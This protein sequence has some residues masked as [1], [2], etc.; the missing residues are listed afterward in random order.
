MKTRAIVT[1]G[2]TALV[3]CGALAGVTSH[4]GMAFASARDE[5]KAER[6]A[7]AE[8][9][10]ARAALA[11]GKGEQAVI[12]A[13]AA[14]GLRPQMTSFRVLLANSYLRAGRFDSARQAFADAMTLDPSNG[15]LPLN[16]ALA[17]IATGDWGGARQTLD[18]H[19]DIIPVSDRGLAI[20]L[21]GD[22]ASAVELLDAAV[23]TP[24]ADAKTRQNFA[25]SLALAGRWQD[26]KTMAAIDLAPSEVDSRIMQWAEFARP[27]SAYDQV[28]AL[29]GVTPVRD[30]GQP[31][32]LALNASSGA[33]LAAVLA[34]VDAFM[35][36]QAENAAQV[37][38]QMATPAPEAAPV[39]MA[40]TAV[41]TAPVEVA[42]ATGP[43]FASVS[44]GPREEVVQRLPSNPTAKP[45]VRVAVAKVAAPAT[46]APEMA[47][48]AG[49][50]SYFVQ[51]GAFENAAVAK[52]AWN[53]AVRR[54]AN[55][56]GQTPSGMNISSRA[57]SFYR[58]SVGGFARNEAVALCQSYK[59]KGGTCFVR[60]HAGDQVAL[61]ARP[62][63]RQ[64]ASR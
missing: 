16:L 28:S 26:A 47:R 14:V 56:V 22:P 49:K 19:K 63:G 45:S 44:F 32:A 51:L 3:A 15:K 64:M 21:A 38:Q 13:E 29:L 27:K 9:D 8:A 61:W 4:G 33:A 55:F 40:D 53:R 30:P 2:L 35:P 1:L 10:K 39:P 18:A 31:V 20:A 34:P 25:L 6:K 43:A 57:G 60:A 62:A 12:H 5:S 54:N 48:A 36:G 58:L 52:D 37:A 50:G 42:P 23:R 17:Q 41:A 46:A 24:Q 11:R 59:A 7:A